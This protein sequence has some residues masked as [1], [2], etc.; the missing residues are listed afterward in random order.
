M[1]FNEFR[2]AGMLPDTVAEYLVGQPCTQFLE[3]TRLCIR[4]N[5][6]RGKFAAVRDYLYATVYRCAEHS[7]RS[8]AMAIAHPSMLAVLRR[9]H[10]AFH[11]LHAHAGQNGYAL[12]SVDLAATIDAL[13]ARQ[14]HEQVAR[15]LCLCHCSG[16]GLD[17]PAQPAIV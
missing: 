10:F 11:I 1:L 9:S 2:A 14:A 7:T 4:P 17:G 3:L 8:Y 6:L 16:E 5:G 15:L 13:R 12:V